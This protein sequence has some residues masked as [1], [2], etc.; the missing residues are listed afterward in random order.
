ML[1][2]YGLELA[3][4]SRSVEVV[5]AESFDERSAK[6]LSYGNHN[7]LRISRILRSLALLGLS[8][9][10]RA[11]LKC[12]EAIYAEHS[13]IIGETTVGYWRRTITITR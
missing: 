8:R 5:R 7:F 10:A 12:L 1:Q 9:Y 2:F 11:F 3:S 13:K 6:W 4:G